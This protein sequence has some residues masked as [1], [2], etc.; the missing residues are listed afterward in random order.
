MCTSKTFS[1]WREIDLFW[2]FLGRSREDKGFS[3]L[4][5]Q[6]LKPR[7]NSKP[8]ASGLKIHRIIKNATVYLFLYRKEND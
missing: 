4:L 8:A 6:Q 7:Q 1:I 5:E 2:S 3:K